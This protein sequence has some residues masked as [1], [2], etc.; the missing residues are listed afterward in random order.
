MKSK[1]PKTIKQH[2]EYFTIT[3]LVILAHIILIP[4]VIVPVLIYFWRVV[5]PIMTAVETQ[6]NYL[7]WYEVKRR[8]GKRTSSVLSVLASEA[9]PEGRYDCILRNHSEVE[10]LERRLKRKCSHIG[11]PWRPDQAV[12]YRYRLKG[13]TPKR[14]RKFSFVRPMSG[15]LPQPIRG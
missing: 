1:K 9:K 10:R 4:I 11:F 8:S 13:G 12:F 5:I 14:N 6:S 3:I 15:W 2:L 7:T